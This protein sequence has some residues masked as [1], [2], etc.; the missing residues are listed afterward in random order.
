MM[1]ETQGPALNHFYSDHYQV[2]NRARLEHLASLELPVEHRT[3][4]ELGSGP[5]DHTFFYLSRGCRVSAVDARKECLDAL[6][7]R[8]PQV[9]A[10]C[11]DL[12]QPS[13]IDELGPFQVVHCY[14]ILYHLEHPELAIAAIGR[15]CTEIAIVET[16]VS[17]GEGADILFPPE[18]PEDYTQSVTGRGCRPT[19]RWVFNELRRW[20]PHVYVTATQPDHV[21]FPVDWTACFTGENLIRCVFVVSRTAL[22]NPLLVPEI[23]SRQKRI[24][25]HSQGEVGRSE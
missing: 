13:G 22:E 17:P 12:N 23:P 11:I 14:G 19:R 7:Q 4:L 3:V 6:N 18:P 9:P 15:V 1:N 5:G 25:D 21:E 20:F 10:Y 8:Y 2:H 16:C 24:G